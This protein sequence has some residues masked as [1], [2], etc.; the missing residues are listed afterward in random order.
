MLTG[1][2]Q[3]ATGNPALIPHGNT[4]L[5]LLVRKRKRVEIHPRGIIFRIPPE[6]AMGALEN[7]LAPAVEDGDADEL[8]HAVVLWQDVFEHAGLLV[9]THHPEKF[10]V[11]AGVV[12]GR[13]EVGRK[14]SGNVVLDVADGE[15][16]V[17]GIRFRVLTAVVVRLE[18]EGV[19]I[20]I[21]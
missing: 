1:N 14:E 2:W 17:Y 13:H 6:I 20:L 16:N 21:N 7:A 19:M 18:A 10:I 3:P 9:E 12:V 15:R 5:K 8:A 11:L 4:A